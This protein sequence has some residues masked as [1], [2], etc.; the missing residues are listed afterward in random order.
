MFVKPFR[1]RELTKEGSQVSSTSHH[2]E[3]LTTRSL[4]MLVTA[5][6]SQGYNTISSISSAV[7]T[8]TERCWEEE[9]KKKASL[10]NEENL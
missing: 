10:K 9:K 3:V 4:R 2:G 8:L 1:L 7:K 5:Y 6:C